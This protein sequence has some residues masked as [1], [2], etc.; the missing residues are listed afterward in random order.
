MTDPSP[1]VAQIAAIVQALRGDRAFVVPNS[2]SELPHLTV[3]D[4]DYGLLGFDI[5][6]GHPTDDRTPSV[7]LNRKL[8]ELNDAG[9]RAGG[10]PVTG[11]VAYPQMAQ[12]LLGTPDAARRRLISMSDIDT[13]RFLSA[14]RSTAA[15]VD[16]E[17]WRSLVDRFAPSVVFAARRS[18]ATDQGAD[19]RRASR[20]LLDTAQATAALAPVQEVLV[21]TGPVGSGKTLVL[22]ARARWLAQSHPGWRIQILCYNKALIP[23]LRSL[24][25][26]HPAIDVS[27]FG[28]FAAALGHRVSLSYED[29]ATRDLDSAIRNGIPQIIDALL[30]DE[31]QDFMPAWLDFALRTVRPGRGGAVVAGDAVQALYRDGDTARVL[32][33]RHVETHQLK[34]PY[35][36]TA[37][38]LAAVGALDPR[39]EVQGASSALDGEPVD[40]VWAASWDEQARCVAWEIRRMIDA[41]EREPGHIAIL[42]TKIAGT[43]RRV[44]DALRAQAIP[45]EVVDKTNSDSFDPT[46]ASVKIITVHS[47]KGHE[48]PVVILFGLEALPDSQSEDEEDLRRARV[49]FVGMTRAQDQLL[50]TYTRY[51]PFLE[52]LEAAG[53]AVRRWTWPDDYEV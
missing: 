50:I 24:V 47:A 5:E 43:I 45:F 37:Q 42:V 22:A 20:F 1:V 49:A 23:Y 32:R 33:G 9:D 29:T 18:G 13:G 19:E 2:G 41:G 11:F 31:V 8:A 30:I 35:R 21:V 6:Y 40:L 27:T 4:R 14:A 48:F 25:S 46:T 34:R 39:F 52:R 38:V 36:S 7:T 53:D 26:G 12:A 15:P 16:D 10:I 28:K 3:I 51:N 17:T 44:S